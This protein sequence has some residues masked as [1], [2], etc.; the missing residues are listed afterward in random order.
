MNKKCLVSETCTLEDQFNCTDVKK[1][2]DDY[3]VD[4]DVMQCNVM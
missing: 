2:N 4:D 3:G 1:V